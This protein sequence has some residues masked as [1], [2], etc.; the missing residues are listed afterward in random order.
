M[1]ACARFVVLAGMA[2]SCSLPTF[3]QEYPVYEYSF[4]SEATFVADSPDN[5]NTGANL[6]AGGFQIGGE[7]PEMVSFSI[8]GEESASKPTM[9]PDWNNS[10]ESSTNTNPLP[11]AE[12]GF[13]DED[14]NPVNG[15]ENE[16]PVGRDNPLDR[17]LSLC[18]LWLFLGLGLCVV[19]KAFG[20]PAPFK[21]GSDAFAS[22][23]W[24]VAAPIGIV[25]LRYFHDSNAWRIGGYVLSI[26]S[27]ASLYYF[28]VQPIVGSE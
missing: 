12:S 25:A 13:K 6:A 24:T 21:D 11:Q 10:E 27:V 2:C 23:L 9:P 26:L 8:K 15:N 7:Q 3:G 14:S 22:L 28:L 4:P 20:A 1:N 18:G 17:L 19:A 5:S 16:T